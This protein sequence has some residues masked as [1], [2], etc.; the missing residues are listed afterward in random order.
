MSI[1]R[2]IPGAGRKFR[3]FTVLDKMI[4]VNLLETVAGIL[5]VLVMI[6]VSQKFIKMLAQAIEGNI[7]NGTVFQLLGLKTIIVT[8]SFLP[9]AIFMAV[10]I[11]IGRMYQDQEISAINSAGGGIFTLYRGIFILLIP[12]A[13]ITA[14]LSLYAAPWAEAK[15][16]ELMHQDGQN[17]DIRGISAGRFSEYSN[18]ELIFYTEKIDDN[19][20]MRH[21]FV[22]NREGDKTGVTNAEFGSLKMLP[23]GLYLILENGERIMGVTGQKDFTI[24]AFKEYAVQIEKNATSLNLSSQAVPTETLWA[25]HSI[26]DVAEVQSRLSTPLGVLLLAFLAVPLAK[27]SPRGGIYGSLLI[28]FGIYFTYGN[29]QRLSFSWVVAGV[30]PTWMGYFWLN[31]LLLMLGLLMLLRSYGWIWLAQVLRKAL[32]K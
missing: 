16:Q 14:G 27:L 11:V 2:K 26:R 22:Q 9:A 30:I 1:E 13:V 23:G 7:A 15:T 24:E 3:L 32:F 18:G 21:V 17:A 5:L 10:L 8:S 6:I 31:G 4:L 29:L 20:R 25:S 28:A 19:G 12:I